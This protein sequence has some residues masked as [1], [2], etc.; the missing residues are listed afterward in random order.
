[1]G[2]GSKLGGLGMSVKKA[3]LSQLLMGPWSYSIQ[4]TQAGTR[5]SQVG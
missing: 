3:C 2:V 5:R 1:V 4:H